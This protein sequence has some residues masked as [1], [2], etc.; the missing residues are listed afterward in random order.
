MD[1]SLGCCRRMLPELG[2]SE[3]GSPSLP[4]Q[5][6]APQEA[7]GPTSQ[8]PQCHDTPAQCLLKG[9]HKPN[10]PCHHPHA[11]IISHHT[12]NIRLYIMVRYHCIR[13]ATWQQLLNSSVSKA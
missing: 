7:A 6:G 2:F 9:V 3:L 13:A 12:A 4:I 1:P 5:V 10:Y 8:L 11:N